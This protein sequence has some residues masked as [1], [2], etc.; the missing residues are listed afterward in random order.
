[1][2]AP[3]PWAR[4]RTLGDRPPPDPRGT[5]LLLRDQPFT[6]IHLLRA[7]DRSA[8]QRSRRPAPPRRITSPGRP[9]R[10]VPFGRGT[11]ME[12][13]KPKQPQQPQGPQPFIPREDRPD[14]TIDLNQ[15]VGDLTVRDLQTLLGG[16]AAPEKLKELAKEKE[17]LSDKLP[18]KDS[19]KEEK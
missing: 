7:L 8:D 17:A 2:P 19:G 14:L 5:I 18:I 9:D 4:A 15:K 11:A 13:E 16:G 6:R 3:R 10:V 12:P 1:M